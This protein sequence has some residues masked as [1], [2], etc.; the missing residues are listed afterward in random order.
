MDPSLVHYFLEKPRHKFKR[1]PIAPLEDDIAGVI[2]QI[3]DI[4]LIMEDIRTYIHCNFEIIG[5][6]KINI[7]LDNVYKQYLKFKEGFEHPGQLKVA[8]YI[9]HH[10]F[11]NEE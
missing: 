4:V 8:Q 10:E 3:L 9:F 1:N 6:K 11:D 5:E 2:L 7:Q